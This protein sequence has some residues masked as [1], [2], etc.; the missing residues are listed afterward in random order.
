M[1]SLQNS[2]EGMVKPLAAMM[3]P[4]VFCTTSFNMSMAM[5]H[6]TMSATDAMR[7]S[8]DAISARRAGFQ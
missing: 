8:T 3:P 1:A 7:M 5:S 6:R 4:H 2:D